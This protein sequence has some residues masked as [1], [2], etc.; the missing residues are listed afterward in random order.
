VKLVGEKNAKMGM[1]KLFETFQDKK[2]NKHMIYV[3]VKIFYFKY[4]T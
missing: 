4:L 1:S 3:I 2:L